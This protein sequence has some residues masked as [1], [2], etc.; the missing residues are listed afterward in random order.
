M[1]Y[2]PEVTENGVNSNSSG[3]RRQVGMNN[4]QQ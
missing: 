1:M 3:E 4:Q 2:V